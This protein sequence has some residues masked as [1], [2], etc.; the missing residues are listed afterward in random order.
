LQNIIKIPGSIL[1]IQ[2]ASIGDVILATALIE[3]LHKEHPSLLID[4]LVR[5]GHETIFTGHPFLHRLLT[6]DKK[7]G[8]YRNLA[9]LITTIRRKRYD[10]VINIQ[11]FLSSG[12]ITV[13]AG[14]TSTTGFSKNPLSL[15][16][17]KSVPHPIGQGLHETFRNHSLLAGLANG[18]PGRPGLYPS[19]DDV[20]F[21]RGF[22]TPPFYTISPASLW[23]T[24]QFPTDRWVEFIGLIPADA[25]IIL[26]GSGTDMALCDRI[27]HDS[28][29]Q[30]IVNLAGRL[31][32]LQSAALMKMARMNYTN[33]SAP[34]HLAS[35]VNAPVTAVF[36]STVP[37]FG[38]GPLSDDS[39]IAEI[40]GQLSCRPCGLHGHRACP[41]GHFRCA[42][43]IPLQ[44]LTSRL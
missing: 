3:S 33:D 4:L 19:E 9:K 44:Q 24:K 13:L 26:L 16:F 8:K 23:F 29:R 17:S 36:C 11:R 7:Q 10:M 43:E 2:T 5:K 35:A 12:L 28:R 20:A 39:A 27:I 31:T 1:I 14:A 18:L 38:F 37:A 22:A 21:V 15:L 42:Y 25:T 6:W 34:M 32:F 30:G 41:E 40:T